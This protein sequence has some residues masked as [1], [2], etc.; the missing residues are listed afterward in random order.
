MVINL[1]SLFNRDLE[2]LA[3]E[4]ARYPTE[5]SLWAEAPGIANSGG[6]LVLHL[7]G[8][9]RHY[10]GFHLGGIPYQRD[11]PAEF[12]LRHVPRAE[13]LALLELARQ[14]VAT[15]A[16]LPPERLA[17]TYAEVVLGAP[18]TVEFYLLHLYGHLRYHTGQLNYH[19]RMTA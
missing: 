1:L 8:N 4:I 16:D 17:Q 9:L 5:A 3:Q 11:R 2:L 19:R 18:T 14:A 7:C 10:I 12:A 13:L 6:T 15:L